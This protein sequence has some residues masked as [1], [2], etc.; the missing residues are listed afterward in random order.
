MPSMGTGPQGIPSTNSIRTVGVKAIVFGDRVWMSL[1][2]PDISFR[3]GPGWLD[4]QLRGCACALI[5]ARGYRMVPL[6]G[7][8]ELVLRGLFIWSPYSSPSCGSRCTTSGECKTIRIAV[9]AFMD[10][11]G[12]ELLQLVRV[13][14]FFSSPSECVSPASR[15]L[16][17]GWEGAILI[18]DRAC[19][20]VSEWN[21]EIESDILK[22]AWWMRK[23]GVE[24]YEK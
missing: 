1:L 5:L 10:N 16:R 13:I 19:E 14:F 18:A 3:W 6:A 24:C 7:V 9:S 15:P 11:S 22:K 4:S 8:T 21:V 12:V 23:M 20:C 17:W 2:C